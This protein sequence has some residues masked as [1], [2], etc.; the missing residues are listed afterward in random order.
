MTADRY[1]VLGSPVARIYPGNLAGLTRAM[2]DA[3]HASL[4]LPGPHKLLADKG[5]VRITA[6]VYEAGELT[7][8][9]S[10]E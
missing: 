6:L 7:W 5:G 10:P 9:M 8:T 1:A 2:K 4:T 3:V